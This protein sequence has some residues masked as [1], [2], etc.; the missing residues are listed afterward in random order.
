MELVD[1]V[2]SKFIQQSVPK[3]DILDMMVQFGLI[4][5]FSYTA[6][7]A[8]YFV[9]CQLKSSPEDLYKQEPSMLDPCPLY[10]HFV[11]GFV[12]HGLF[13]RLVSRSISWCCE[14]W[15][16][17][18]P[19][20]YQNGAWFV[21]IEKQM[22]YD[23][24][25]LCNKSFIKIVLK[26]RRQDEVVSVETPV[27][28]ARRVRVFLEDS[29]QNL[30]QELPYLSGLQYELCIACPYCQHKCPNHGQ[31]SCTDENCLHFLEVKEEEQLICMKSVCDKVYTVH[32]VEMW[33]SR[34][35]QVS[36]SIEHT[37][38]VL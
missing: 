10:L 37:Q 19:N 3:E 29:L 17:P 12:P 23:F 13:T 26:Q 6:T 28:V 14:T 31:V 35:S 30:S 25:L 24:F 1:H 16:T 2:F 27:E 34:T 36:C 8:E 22:I 9:P 20:L 18:L 5:K 11:D 32:G 33:F 15:R 21:L 4:A 38:Q 7:D